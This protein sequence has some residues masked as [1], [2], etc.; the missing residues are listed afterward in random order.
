MKLLS[1][2]VCESE[3]DIISQEGYCLR[4]KCQECGYTSEPSSKPKKKQPKL[5][6][7][8]I[9]KKVK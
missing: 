4:I 5:P 9:I 7:V 6:E 8:T 3:V 1:C 2:L